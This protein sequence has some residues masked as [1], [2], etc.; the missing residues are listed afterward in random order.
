MLDVSGWLPTQ[1]V[2]DDDGHILKA[3]RLRRHARKASEWAGR[4]GRTDVKPTSSPQFRSGPRLAVE[5]PVVIQC[6]FCRGWAVV[7]SPTT[8]DAAMR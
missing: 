5:L 4:V 7:E 2:E 6:S 1:P 8:L 3:Y